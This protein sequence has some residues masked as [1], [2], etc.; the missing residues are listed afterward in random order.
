MNRSGPYRRR[1]GNQ[2]QAMG[3]N[4][5]TT[6]DKDEDDDEQ[7]DE[8]GDMSAAER[9]YVAEK[10]A[11]LKV[12]PPFNPDES[13]LFAELL[14]DKPALVRGTAGAKEAVEQKMRAMAKRDLGEWTMPEELAQRLVEG[15]TVLFESE[16]EKARVLEAA[17]KVG[18]AQEDKKTKAKDEQ[19]KENAE[20][21][22]EDDAK[23]A[24]S[25]DG[26]EPADDKV[27]FQPV[28]DSSKEEM[29]RIYAAGQWQT[30]N[31]HS[32]DVLKEVERMTLLNGTYLPR[33]QNEILAKIRSLLPEQQAQVD[34]GVSS[35]R[36]P[37]SRQGQAGRQR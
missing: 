13:K 1:G 18:R 22:V 25:G 14:A 37:Q 32:A 15:E 26:S 19:E 34:H 11:A 5:D 23:S 8:Y 6:D 30:G 29:L 35:Q 12:E 21:E 16:D 33:N 31:T 27:G 4:S 36:Q 17:K 3:A 9:A 10:E 20:D 7:D 24:A 2:R 28:P